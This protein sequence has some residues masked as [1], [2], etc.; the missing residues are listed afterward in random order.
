MQFRYSN[1]I[2]LAIYTTYMIY[3]LMVYRIAPIQFF[4]YGL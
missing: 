1:E 2:L 3:S 4:L